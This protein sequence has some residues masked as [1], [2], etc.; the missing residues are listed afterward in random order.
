M[1][2]MAAE[3]FMMLI[4]V[5]VRILYEL[6]QNNQRTYLDNLQSNKFQEIL[7]YQLKFSTG[8]S[9]QI[10]I[11]CAKWGDCKCNKKRQ[12]TLAAYIFKFVGF[13]PRGRHLRFH[14]IETPFLQ[15]HESHKTK[16]IKIFFAQSG[17][18]NNNNYME[19]EN[20]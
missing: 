1:N 17:H 15:I 3:N 19:S 4:L 2:S 7:L 6:R 9:T 8:K 14:S 16:H 13:I 5:D 11:F 12:P 10:R 20:S 18:E